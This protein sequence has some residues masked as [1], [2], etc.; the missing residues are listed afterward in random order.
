MLAGRDSDAANYLSLN[1]EKVHFPL[2]KTYFQNWM[3]QVLKMIDLVVSG[4]YAVPDVVHDL[5]RQQC[6]LT[7]IDKGLPGLNVVGEKY[8]KASTTFRA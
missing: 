4:S 6:F 7:I 3:R 8:E 1:R 5:L 2:T